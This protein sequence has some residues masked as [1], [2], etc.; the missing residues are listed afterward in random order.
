MLSTLSFGQDTTVY[1]VS[2]RFE[3]CQETD[4]KQLDHCFNQEVYK[5]LYAQI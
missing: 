5:A 2:P 4:L 3:N 1:Q